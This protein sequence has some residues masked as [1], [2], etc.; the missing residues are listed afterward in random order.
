MNNLSYNTSIVTAG[1]TAFFVG[2]DYNHGY[3]LW[4]SD[5]SLKGTKMVTDIF[6]GVNGSYPYS[7]FAYNKEIYFGAY[8]GLSY[9]NSFFKSNGI[10]TKKLGNISVDYSYNSS[11]YYGHHKNILQKF[12]LFFRM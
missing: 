8:D 3:E 4:K 1:N 10:V 11:Y 9:T 2:G 12:Y 7:L 6:K 5:G